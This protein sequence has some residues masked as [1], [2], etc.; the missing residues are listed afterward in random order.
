[1]KNNNNN[2]NNKVENLVNILDAYVDDKNLN[3]ISAK[4]ND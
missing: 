4:L 2:N 1:M 3:K